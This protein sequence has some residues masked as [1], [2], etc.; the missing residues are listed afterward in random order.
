MTRN[1]YNYCKKKNPFSNISQFNIPVTLWFTCALLLKMCWMF[2]C[3]IGNTISSGFK[4]G[5]Q[6]N[7]TRICFSVGM[8]VRVG[9]FLIC[10]NGKENACSHFFDWT[11]YIKR[12]RRNSS[13]AIVIVQWFSK[14]SLIG[15]TTP[16]P[17][18]Q[19]RLG[20]DGYIV[21]AWL[22][23][24]VQSLLPAVNLSSGP[25]MWAPI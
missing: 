9:I 7:R 2:Y 18:H 16:T 11:Y 24:P 21:S 20:K 13:L 10:L 1:K 5:S 6:K 4:L 25:L 17:T 8:W 19:L 14:M 22:A 12:E 23:Q 15:Y 3:Q